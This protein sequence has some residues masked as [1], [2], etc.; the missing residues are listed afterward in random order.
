MT[1]MAR[2]MYIFVEISIKVPHRRFVSLS[3]HIPQTISQP[4]HV[5]DFVGKSP[6]AASWLYGMV[7]CMRT[8]CFSKAFLMP[9]TEVQLTL[10]T[11]LE[12]QCLFLTPV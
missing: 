10:Q 3:V 12:A 2:D 5:F 4:F 1:L 6:Q 9:V 7:N 11:Y 8:G